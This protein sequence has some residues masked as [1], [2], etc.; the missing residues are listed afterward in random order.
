MAYQ[1]LYRKYRPQTFG[2]VFGQNHITKILSNQIRT[3]QFTH[4][5]LFCGTRGTGKTS[6]AKIFARAINCLNPINGEP[7]NQCEICRSNL[8]APVDIIEMDAA[9]NN[10]VDEIRDLKDKIRFAPLESKY[11]VYIIDE[12]HMLSTSAF[13][14]LLKTLEEPPAHAIFILATT[15]QQKLPATIISRCQRFEFRR[16]EIKEI[17]EC[18]TTV[19]QDLNIKIEEKGLLSIAYSA[20]GGLRDALS[21]LD[22]CIAYCENN[23]SYDQVL[24]VIGSM[25]KD[26]IFQIASAI[27]DSDIP[28]VLELLDKIMI[29]GRDLTVF[30]NDLIL[31][32]RAIMLLESNN[33]VIDGIMFNSQEVEMLKEQGQK[34]P[35]ARAIKIIELISSSFYNMKISSYPR[36]AL[37]VSLIK[38]CKNVAQNLDELID[39]V[40][41]LEKQIEQIKNSEIIAAPKAKQD[42]TIQLPKAQPIENK[43]F[44][45]A[46]KQKPAANKDS[47]E[48]FEYFLSN[49]NDGMRTMFT[50]SKWTYKLEGNHLHLIAPKD[51][52]D[53]LID[54]LQKQSEMF[55]KI[56]NEKYSG[57]SVKFVRDTDSQQS[58]L[59]QDAIDFFGKENIITEN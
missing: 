11:K 1:A 35:S 49:I 12:V 48:I 36:I 16:I 33:P 23:I 13:N 30:A 43:A 58:M 24:D 28:L 25:S 7:C 29:N 3:N 2:Q 8:T 54:N 37:E 44:T 5:Y 55:N 45:P 53:V 6:V 17:L 56:I 31:H 57:I 26:F 19:T 39:K 14:A 9:S 34:C 59:T 20:Q 4:A 21:L 50:V 47:A 51:C 27:I 40:Q 32:F 41:A 52:A 42:K 10:G 46:L 15:E 38:A 18:L 22:Q